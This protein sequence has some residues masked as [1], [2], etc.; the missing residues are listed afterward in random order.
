MQTITQLLL[1]CH[2]PLLCAAPS[3]GHDHCN[4]CATESFPQLLSIPSASDVLK[5]FS[6][7]LSILLK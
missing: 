2:L 7:T 1:D 4:A 5:L 3:E 6:E